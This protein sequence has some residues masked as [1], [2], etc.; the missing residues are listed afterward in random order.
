MIKLLLLFWTFFKIGLFTIGGGYAMIPMINDEVISR[1]WLTQEELVD[2]MGIAESTPGPFA[3]NIATFVGMNEAG[4]LGAI[5]TTIGVVLPSF[6]IIL[7]ISKI[8][9]LFLENRFVKYALTGVRPVVVGLIA[10]VAIGLIITS[11]LNVS[12]VTNVINEFDVTKIS[13]SSIIIMVVIF[14]L[15]RFKKLNKPILLI[16]ISAV[17]GIVLYG[18]IGLS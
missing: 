15:S 5:F 9:T 11:I 17:L 8:I 12:S 2:F 14:T 10:A 4:V 16:L 13:I 18:L 1:G 3:I 6:I 7:I